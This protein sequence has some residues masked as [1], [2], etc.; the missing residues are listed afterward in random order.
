MSLGP[1]LQTESDIF[2][3]WYDGA[4]YGLPVISNRTIAVIIVVGIL[5]VVAIVCASIVWKRRRRRALAARAQANAQAQ[6]AQNVP[7]PGSYPQGSF[8][9]PGV[10]GGGQNPMFMNESSYGGGPLQPGQ[11]ATGGVNG[12]GSCTYGNYYANNPGSGNGIG[13]SGTGYGAPPNAQGGAHSMGYFNNN[14]T[15]LGTSPP[16]THPYYD[17]RLNYPTNSNYM[18][19]GVVAAGIP[20]ETHAQHTYPNASPL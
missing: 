15:T 19:S 1:S 2:F 8:A 11:T 10:G 3:D 17:T 12:A 5:V 7:P 6:N 16:S 18:G 14:N 9:G 20:L 4:D 13:V